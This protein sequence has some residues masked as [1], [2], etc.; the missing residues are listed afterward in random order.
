MPRNDVPAQ[1]TPRRHGRF[2]LVARNDQ[3]PL[4]PLFRLHIH[5]HIQHHNCPQ[6][7][8]SLFRHSKQF[9]AVL[10]ELYSLDCRVEF[11]YFYAFAR[12]D[13]PEADGVVGGAG[14]EEGG[15]GVDVDGPESTLVAVIGTEAFAVGGE[16]G[17]DH[18]I[19]GAGEEDVAVFGVSM[20]KS[21]R[22]S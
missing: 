4:I 19:F 11:P 3:T 20:G 7:P 13:V 15:A 17:A 2:A 22:S 8:H 18:L 16:P 6:I 14:G 9:G 1:I 12:A 5:Y 21:Q 10:I